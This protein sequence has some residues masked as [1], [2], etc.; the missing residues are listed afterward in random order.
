[1][2]GIAIAWAL[3]GSGW[4]GARRQKNKS[5]RTGQELDRRAIHPAKIL[6]ANRCPKGKQGKQEKGSSSRFCKK[7]MV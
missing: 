3:A 6:H 4:A 7:G 2:M 5:A 1:M